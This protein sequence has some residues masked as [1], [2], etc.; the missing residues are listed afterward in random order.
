MSASASAVARPAA[1]TRV[2]PVFG[3]LMLVMLMASLDSTIVST[4]LPT[5]AGDLGGIDK[6]FWVVTAY[7]L[8]STITTPVAGKLGDMYGR[9]LVL[10]VALIVFLT[11]S[12]LCG[13]SRDMT[14]LIAFRGLQG[15]GGG[16][17]MVSTQA[18]IGDVVSPR[19]RGRYSG[20]MGAV[21][22]ISTVLGPLLGGLFVDHLSWQ[23]IFY[24]NVPIGIAAFVVLQIVLATPALRVKRQI[25]YPGMALLA[26]GLT[27]I[28]LY[29][30]LGGSTYPWWSWQMILL[31]VASVV[32]TIAF[33]VAERRAKEPTVPLALFRNRV[34]TV[35]SIVGF[36]V[37][38]ALFGSVTYIPLYLQVV[39]GSSPTRSGLQLLPLM[40]G[41]LIA[42]IGSGQLISRFGRYK[43]FPI[44]GTGLMVVGL[45]LLSRLTPGTSI[46][47][48]D[49]YLL[50]LGF[51]LGFVM[52]VLILAVQN[53]ADY[54]DLGVATASATLFRSM[55][56]TIGVPIFGAIFTNQFAS[57]LASRLPPGAAGELP[58][59]LGPGQIG[60][61]PPSIRDPYIDAYA[62][63]LHPV[64]LIAAFVAV[65]AFAFIWL[66]EERPLRQTV[67]DQGIGDSF[68]SPRDASSIDELEARLSKLAQRENRHLVYERLAS[69]ADIDVT[70]GEAWLLLRVDQFDA[71]SADEL[72]AR[73]KLQPDAVS[74]LLADLGTQGLVEG[75][76]QVRLTERGHAAVQ[77]MAEARQEALQQFLEEW[78]PEQ[79]PEVVQLLER[80]ARS[81]RATPPAGDP[82][83][84]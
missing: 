30:S 10:Q 6:L 62:A 5:I 65:A 82:V 32:L 76:P 18:V 26:G 25:D 63:A 68:A 54:R 47:L 79:H 58:S 74:G 36:I 71:A 44:V 27:S 3:A 73:Y 55:G 15:L 64:F 72:A 13:L 43:L 31:L 50:V 37:G 77:K 14:E 29:T 59:H 41:V 57:Q 53:A 4:A 9:K 22:G 70:P 19:E 35:S 51:G 78:E 28:V 2:G 17:L 12:A 38:M 80:F 56:G 39:R 49:L 60:Q 34:F 66:L 46:V 8:T 23:W 1:S 24:V 69:A 20:L 75:S 21:F 52:Q 45:L 81:L 83:P 16:A 84:A 40:A 7:L 61:L 48:A 42:S 33:V 11:G 67:A